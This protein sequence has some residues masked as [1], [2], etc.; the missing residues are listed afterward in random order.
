MRQFKIE[1]SA[2]PLKNFNFRMDE[3]DFAKA[4]KICKSVHGYSLR[5]IL[6]YL[7]KDEFLKD[8]KSDTGG[9]KKALSHHGKR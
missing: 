3:A 4:D 1:P 5:T 7:I 6:R 2:E 9:S 8:E